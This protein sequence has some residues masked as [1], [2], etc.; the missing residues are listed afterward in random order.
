M[1]ST[2]VGPT[3]I[4]PATKINRYGVINGKKRRVQ[5]KLR[6][7]KVEEWTRTCG[8]ALLL[9][10]GD[11][12]P[13]FVA[14]HDVGAHVQPEDLHILAASGTRTA[15]PKAGVAPFVSLCERGKPSNAL[16][17]CSFPAYSIPTPSVCG[18]AL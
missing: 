12:S 9:A 13:H 4:S 18:S 11:A 7:F 17:A 14:D 6:V 8:E 2:L 3:S 15:S 5:L 10:T 1:K 16:C